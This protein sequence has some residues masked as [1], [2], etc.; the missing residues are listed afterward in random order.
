MAAGVIAAG[1]ML[2]LWAW[3]QFKRLETP[4]CHRHQP[5]KL[6]TSGAFHYTRNPMYLGL[7]LMLLGVGIGVGRWPMF[8]P[9]G[10]FF[11][12]MNFGFI[13]CEER[14]MAQIFGGEYLRY[15]AHTR[16]WV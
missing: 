12:V 6:V 14:W 8:L 5:L 1:L 13:P 15:C 4:I 16:R 3:W 9:V 10:G 11:L 2:M 7:L